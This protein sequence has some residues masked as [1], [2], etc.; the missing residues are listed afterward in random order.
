MPT[1]DVRV[2]EAL[3]LAIDREWINNSYYEGDAIPSAVSHMAE[4]WHFFQDRWAPIPGPD[5]KIGAAGGWPYPYDPE[6]A[7]E[8]LVEAGYPD[9][10][11]L[12]FFAPTNLGGWPE[13]SEVGEVMAIMWGGDR[14]RRKPYD[15][16]VR[17]CPGHI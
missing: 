6:R 13:I 17:P 15:F 4:W 2:R 3:N 8:L 10:F 11:E 7:R 9:G 16:G 12:D 14:H 1:R 5:G